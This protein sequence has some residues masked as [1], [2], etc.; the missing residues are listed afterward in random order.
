MLWAWRRKWNLARLVLA[1][2]CLWAV[3]VDTGPRLARLRL[4]ALPGFDYAAEVAALRESARYGE[5]LVVA[6]AGLEAL[7]APGQSAE[8]AV[9]S[10]ERERTLAARDSWVRIAGEVG[11][12]ALSGRAESL[13]GLLGAVTADLFVVGD[14]RDLLIQ[15]TKL[16]VDGEADPVLVVLSAVGLFTTLAPEVDWAPSLLKAARRV[17][18]MSRGLGESIVRLGKSGAK[19]PIVALA[20]DAA[21]LAKRAGPGGALRVLRHAD[22]V[23]DV[24]RLAGF[25]KAERRGAFALHVAGREGAELVRAGPEGAAA[26]LKATAK[27]ERGVAWLRAGGKAVLRPHPIIGL[28]KGVWKGNAA[29]LVQRAVERLDPHGWWVLPLCAAWLFV[30][31]V[32]LVGGRWKGSTVR[33]G[34]P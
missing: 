22:D 30:E 31:G 10:A 29:A 28:V 19:G 6:D 12:G 13:E 21:E 2:F 8:R 9:L 18:A 3:A 32:W 26:L 33:H 14:V 4:A 23:S 20:G 15:G 24:S 1:L 7:G 27:G 25:V 34:A 5:A 11:M 17:G 16:A